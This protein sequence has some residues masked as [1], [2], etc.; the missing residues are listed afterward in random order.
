MTDNES[1][2]EVPQRVLPY[3]D[4]KP[5]GTADFYFAINATFRF[6]LGRF[7]IEGLRQ[8]WTD[9]GKRY[10]APV[11]VIWKNRGLAGVASY[12]KAFFAAEPGA[13]VEVTASENAVTLEVKVCP[14]I[15]HLRKHGR[16]I[17]PCFCQHC[18]YVSEAMAAP[19]GFTVRV[20]GGD[21]ACRQILYRQDRALPPQDIG[22]IK[23]AT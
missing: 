20:S 9:L 3:T 8:Y 1:N 12:W 13:D 18:Y 7:G 21:G 5:V 4:R 16:Q 19:A 22:E 14:A 11:S 15:H 6:I 23:E 2:P 17:V 10:Y